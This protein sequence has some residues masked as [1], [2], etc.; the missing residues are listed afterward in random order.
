MLKR[1]A[2]FGLLLA[3]AMGNASQE[4]DRP[5][6]AKDNGQQH[7]GPLV[8]LVNNETCA[9]NTQTANTKPPH[10][11]TIPEWWLCILGVPTLIYLIIQ[12]DATRKA[13]NAALLNAQAVVN[14]ERAWILVTKTREGAKFRWKIKNFG[15]TP[16]RVVAIRHS[17]SVSGRLVQTAELSC[18]PAILAP[19]EDWK[20]A[21]FD[22]SNW[23]GVVARTEI[24]HFQ[25]LIQYRDVLMGTEIQETELAMV[26]D[27]VG[28]FSPTESREHNRAT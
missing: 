26:H 14:A 6:L 1:L 24:L 8:S 7:K 18:L 27:S 17:I 10:W 9:P 12:T 25:C 2:I 20:F 13:A 3:I 11:Y 19:G 4:Q 16:G 28:S 5:K 21:E 23:P 15:R 22:V